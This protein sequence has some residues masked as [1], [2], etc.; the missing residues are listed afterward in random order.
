M[1]GRKS[2]QS[3]PMYAGKRYNLHGSDPS[4]QCESLGLESLPI[5]ENG[6][7]LGGRIDP[8]TGRTRL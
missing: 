7:L 5:A 3:L 1:I 4:K 8:R 6:S 2:D